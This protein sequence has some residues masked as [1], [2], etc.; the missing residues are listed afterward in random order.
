MEKSNR[1]T[2]TNPEIVRLGKRIEAI[3]KT[4]QLKTREVA[5]GADLETENLRKY[6]KGTQEM[7]ITTML[8]I[9]KSLGVSV[10]DLFDNE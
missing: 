3:I 6:I 1:K 10:A 7:K 9:A 2:T 4:K 8:R 5:H